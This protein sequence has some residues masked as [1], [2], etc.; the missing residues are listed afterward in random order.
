MKIDGKDGRLLLNPDGSQQDIYALPM[1]LETWQKTVG[2]Y[3]E[4]HRVVLNGRVVQVLMDEDAIMKGATV[5]PQATN[6]LWP[7]LNIVPPGVRGPVVIAW[8]KG[9][10]T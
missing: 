3:V 2:G 9:R 8:G 6:L 5:N 10:M 1:T 7:H 4:T